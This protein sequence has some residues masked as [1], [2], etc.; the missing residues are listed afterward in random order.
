M[1]ATFQVSIIALRSGGISTGVTIWEGRAE[2]AV[3]VRLGKEIQEVLRRGD[4]EL[5]GCSGKERPQSKQI[6]KDS[7]RGNVGNT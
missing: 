4:G 1:T 5:N 3:F 6:L 7:S 2:R